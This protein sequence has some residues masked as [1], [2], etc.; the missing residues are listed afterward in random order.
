[1]S[2]LQI[3]GNRDSFGF[4][5]TLHPFD[6]ILSAAAA[7]LVPQLTVMSAAFLIITFVFT[8]LWCLPAARLGS[9]LSGERRLVWRNRITGSLFL[10]AGLGLALARRS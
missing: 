3:D 5:I 7:P 10:G 8:W 1:M 9:W 4:Q 6:A 2:I